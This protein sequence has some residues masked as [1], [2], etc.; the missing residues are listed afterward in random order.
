MQHIVSLSGGTASAV[1][2]DRVLTRYGPENTTLW[3]ADTSW[4]DE[5]LAFDH[6][7]DILKWVSDMAIDGTL[8]KF[9]RVV[10]ADNIH[11]QR[12]VGEG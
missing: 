11:G 5:D 10:L 4:E 9:E 1:A 3:F 2:A 8:A 6:T 12:K 7:E